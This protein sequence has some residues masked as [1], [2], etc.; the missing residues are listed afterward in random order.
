MVRRSC[1]SSCGLREMPRTGRA[2]CDAD[3]RIRDADGRIHGAGVG[4]IRDAD[5]R[6][7]SAS[8]SVAAGHGWI[9]NDVATS[10]HAELPPVLAAA[11]ATMGRAPSGTSHEID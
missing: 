7:H 3:G 8:A 5:G 10:A 1:S 11:L 4:R 6:I 2:G 9:R